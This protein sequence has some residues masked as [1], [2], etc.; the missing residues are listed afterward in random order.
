MSSPATIYF[1]ESGFTGNNLLHPQQT[2]FSYGSVRSDEEEAKAVVESLIGRYNVQNKELK[3]ANLIKYNRGRRAISEVLRHFEGRMKVSV[4]EKKYAL[5]AKFFEYIF[6]PPLQQNNFL[7]Y[8]LDFHRFISN[9][10]YVEFVARG[11]GAE[12]IFEDFERLM[13]SGSFEGLESLFSASSHPEISPILAQIKDFAIFNR[14]AIAQELSGYVGTGAG[15]WVL[16]LTNTALFSLLAQWGKDF[17][18][19]TAVC[20]KSKPLASDQELFN[21]MIGRTDR[22]FSLLGGEESPITF[23]LGGPI[24]LVDSRTTPGVQLADCVAAAFAYACDRRADDHYAMEWRKYFETTLIYGSV[25]PD[26]EHVDLK[27]LEVQRN[28]VLLVELLER[29]KR[30]VDLLDGMPQ[31]VAMI[32]EALRLAPIPIGA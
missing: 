4:S 16:D 24:Q 12:E 3:G 14:N 22:K 2:V 15:K 30:G 31:Y 21:V 27:R 9:I 6:E 7:F 20:D 1:D 32:T 10:L 11:A 17:G 13:R 26:L 19:L 5:A 8:R 29:S 18:P 25:F 28:A 23:N